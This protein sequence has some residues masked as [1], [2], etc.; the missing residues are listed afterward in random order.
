[1]CKESNS[2][3]WVL[4]KVL[5]V[6]KRTSPSCY[7]IYFSVFCLFVCFLNFRKKSLLFSRPYLFHSLYKVLQR[8][9]S[10]VLFFKFFCSLIQIVELLF[11]FPLFFQFVNLCSETQLSVYEFIKP[12]QI[13][14]SKIF[15]ETEQ[16]SNSHLCRIPFWIQCSFANKPGGLHIPPNQWR[17]NNIQI[18]C[19]ERLYL[20]L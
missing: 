14:S 10:I 7:L 6:A 11:P 17:I 19:L 4:P 18:L 1:M 9:D 20:L 3:P 5:R 13:L 8:C 2:H 16:I 12:V 15:S